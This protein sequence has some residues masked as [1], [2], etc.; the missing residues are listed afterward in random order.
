MGV[1]YHSVDIPNDPWRVEVLVCIVH[2]CQ[3]SWVLARVHGAYEGGSQVYIPTH[4]VTK[5]NSTCPLPNPL[6]PHQLPSNYK[7]CYSLP[8]SG[9]H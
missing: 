3:P 2:R 1:A 9:W 5:A 6:M 8:M 7:G 4:M